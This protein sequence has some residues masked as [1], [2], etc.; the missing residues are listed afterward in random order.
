MQLKEIINQFYG[1]SEDSFGKLKAIFDEYDCHKGEVICWPG[2]VCNDIW[3]VGNGL[4]ATFIGGMDEQ[5]IYWFNPEGSPLISL[6]AYIKGEKGYE[7]FRILE[8]SHLY[9]TTKNSLFQLYKVDVD[10]A[11]WGRCLMERQLL[12]M[13]HW[14]IEMAQSTAQKR[15]E[16]I[17]HEQ[18]WLLQRVSI[19]Q[20]AEYMGITRVS[21][22]RIRAKI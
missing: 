9:H 2:K 19:E 4:A 21:L 10:I 5:K 15:Y 17:L 18:P 16:V 11:N 14:Y 3:F 13:E 12:D 8:N 20:L 22:S 1:L 7:G 6:N